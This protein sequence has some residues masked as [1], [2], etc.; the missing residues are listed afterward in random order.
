MKLNEIL[1]YSGSTL[2]ILSCIIEISPLKIYPWKYIAKFIG[3]SINGEM[4][5]KMSELEKRMEHLESQIDSVDNHATNIEKRFE[6]RSAINCRTRILRFGDE[7]LHGVKHS[8]EHFDQILLDITEYQNYCEL[9]PE[10]RN[11]VTKMTTK[12]IQDVYEK[13]MENKSFL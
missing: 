9:H 5:K 6:E 10:F 7:I 11:N 13:C 2:F 12:E 3:N 8:K 1:A 4:L